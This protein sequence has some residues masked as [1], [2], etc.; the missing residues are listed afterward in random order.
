MRLLD[1]PGP[2]IQRAPLLVVLSGPSGVGKDA[3]L[4]SLRTLQQPRHFVV[5]ATTRTMRP[6]EVDGVDYLFLPPGLFTEMVDKGEF[7]EC[8]QV[9]DNWYGVPKQQVRDAFKKGMDVIMKVDVQGAATIRRLAPEA[10]FI[11]MVPSSMEELRERL[12]RRATETAVGLETRIGIAH[13]EMEQLTAFDYVVVNRD[14]CLDEAVGCI[15]AIIVA[16][17]C[18]IPPRQVSV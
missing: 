8:A 10:V 1:S 5:T 12:E 15:D 2:S 9:Y 7:L 3:A 14:S 13:Q 16:E 17:K 11:F 18:R 6:G 4:S